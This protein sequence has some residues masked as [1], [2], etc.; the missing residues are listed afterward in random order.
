MAKRIGF[1]TYDRL[2]QLSRDDQLVIRRYEAIISNQSTAAKATEAEQ[3]QERQKK[4]EEGGRVRIPTMF[5]LVIEGVIWSDPS[6]DWKA[7]D[8][9]VLRSCWD[10]HDRYETFVEWIGKMEKENIP[11]L[12]PPQV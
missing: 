1:V 6:I 11:L 12:N 5:P 9:L 8:L 10:Y 2:P 3:E 4:A 7:F